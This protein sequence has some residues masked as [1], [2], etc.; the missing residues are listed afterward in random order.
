MNIRIILLAL[1]VGISSLATAEFTT[2][3]RAY[4]I[5]LSEFRA[6]AS[7]NGV[8]GFKRCHECAEEF[9]HVTS[10]TQY[11]V[12]NES[13]ELADFRFRLSGAHNRNR[14]TVIVMHHLESD[15]VTS[16]SVTL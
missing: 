7:V 8:A 13:V 14:K 12:N 2:V 6:P 11:I 15:T 4:E 1:M 10:A 5:S 9:I 3:T 16:M